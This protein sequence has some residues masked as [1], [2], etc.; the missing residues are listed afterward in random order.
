MIQAEEVVPAAAPQ[1][2]PAVS[3]TTPVT[4][5]EWTKHEWKSYVLGHSDIGLITVAYMHTEPDWVRA[6]YV[7]F[8]LCLVIVAQLV[9]P[10]IVFLDSIDDYS[11]GFCPRGAG[12]K[13]RILAFFIGGIYMAKLNFLFGKKMF[14]ALEK[15]AL[16]NTDSGSSMAQLCVTGDLLMNTGYEAMVYIL[17]LWIVFLTPQ[18][19]DMVLN[20]LAME[21]ILLLDDE[22]KEDYVRNHSRSE[23]IIHAY[24]QEFI[25]NPPKSQGGSL[26]LVD[27][28]VILINLITMAGV[29]FLTIYLPICKP[30]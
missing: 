29:Y 5:K 23:S 12:V 21:F 10:I 24:S 8:L 11:A 9:I 27:R 30:E 3:P 2:T 26:N 17:N 13:T 20:A 4:T 18:A 28:I 1:S 19:L 7:R 14:E 25:L 22:I 15:A 16:S 6:Y